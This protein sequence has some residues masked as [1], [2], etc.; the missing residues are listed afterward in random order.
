MIA[1]IFPKV[2]TQSAASVG[3]LAPGSHTRHVA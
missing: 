3:L 1:F 2:Q